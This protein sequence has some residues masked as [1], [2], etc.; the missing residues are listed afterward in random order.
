[1]SLRKHSLLLLALT[2][3]AAL[4][5]WLLTSPAT[6]QLDKRPA[7]SVAPSSSAQGNLNR[8]IIKLKT[9]SMGKGVSQRFDAQGKAGIQAL[10]D[11]AFIHALGTPVELNYL[12]TIHGSTQVATLN[13]GLSRTE[14][15]ALVDTLSQNPAVEFAE[16]DEKAY[17]FMTP[18]DSYYNSS[19]WGLKSPNTQIAGANFEF[20]WDRRV[21]A[22]T[23][24]NGANVIVAVLDTGY[25]RHA[26]IAANILEPGYDFITADDPPTNT[27]FT[28]A[29]DGGGRDPDA[30]DPGDWNPTTKADCPASY[31]SWHGTHVAGT[32]AAVGNNASGVIGGAYGAKILPVRVL[33]VCGGY[34]SDIQEGMYWAA[35]LHQINNVTNPDIAKVINLS[36]GVSGVCSPSYQMAVNDVVAAGVTVVAATGNDSS[37]TTISSPANCSNVIAVTA[38]TPAGDNATYA[39]AGPG[40][41]I[42]APGNGI[43][44]TS[45]TGTTGPLADTIAS[46]NGTSMA[47]PHVAAAAALLLQVNPALSPADIKNWLTANARPFPNGTN[48]VSLSICGAGMLDAFAAVKALQSGSNTRP[49]MSSSS[50]QSG[51]PGTTLQFT[52]TAADAEGDAVSFIASGLP[53]GATFNSSSG[54]FRWANPVL[55]TYTL[56]VTPSDAGGAGFVQTIQLTIANAPANSMGGGGGGGGAMEWEDVLWLALLAAAVLGYN[57]RQQTTV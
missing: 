30:S 45:N 24:V 7:M 15:N 46:K 52:V 57:T 1:M 18:N 36:L 28:T 51:A 20:A 32:V 23:P 6:A 35:G 56:N 8:L 31:S 12:K 5:A 13:E 2:T 40:T 41:T 47:S 17:P 42:S 27:D 37:S 10:N 14:M 34:S 26:D 25:R 44:S 33:G 39:N 16:I 49:S 55:G 9:D 21:G 50:V 4:S 53:S 54:Q 48:C 3:L 38:H 19:L 43:F 11:R 29:N 22:S